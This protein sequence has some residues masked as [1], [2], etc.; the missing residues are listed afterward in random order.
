MGYNSSPEG[1]DLSVGL[2]KYHQVFAFLELQHV[3][4]A[5]VQ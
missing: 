2:N 5:E 4:P 3:A 1:A